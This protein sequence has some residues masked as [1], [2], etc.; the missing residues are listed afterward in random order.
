MDRAER[1]G[2]V[3]GLE[4][5]L[6][7]AVPGPDHLEGDAALDGRGQ[8]PGSEAGGWVSSLAAGSLDLPM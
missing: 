5:L 6:D 8:D 7:I 1:P 4:T 3:V 2:A